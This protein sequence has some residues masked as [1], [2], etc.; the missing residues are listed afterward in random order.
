MLIEPEGS[1][2]NLVCST[3]LKNLAFRARPLT[4]L[5]GDG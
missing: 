3:R 1:D 5:V 4:Y 2:M